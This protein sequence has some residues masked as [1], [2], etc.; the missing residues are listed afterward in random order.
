MNIVITMAGRGSRFRAEGYAEPKYMIKVRGS[1]LFAWSM[2]SLES[3]LKNSS[4]YF[5]CV[6]DTYDK[7]FIAAEC[8]A[9]G[10]A[11]YEVCLLDDFTD[12]QATTAKHVIDSISDSESILIFNI[13]T[14]V[15]PKW[16]N[17][18]FIDTGYSGWIP[19]FR[20]PGDHWSFVDVD[21]HG[22]AKKVVEKERISELATV[23]LYWFKNSRSYIDSYKSTYGSALDSSGEKYIAPMYNAIIN[24]GGLVKVSELPLS[25][26]IALG[27]PKEVQEY[28][29]GFNN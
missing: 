18:D 19:C 23:G 1:S 3:Y 21:D 15:S 4:I 2:K 14:H 10:I 9:L 6:K 8:S 17:W 28:L 27:T 29:R 25:T 20:A 11:D 24:D 26:I 5:V 7:A 13:D 22:F 12:G 16:L